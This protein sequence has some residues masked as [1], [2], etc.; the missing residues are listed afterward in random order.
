MGGGGRGRGNERGVIER[1][2]KR[3]VR[4]KGGG[5]E[6]KEREREGGKTS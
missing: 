4:G 6:G 3:G 1:E 5:G 2:G